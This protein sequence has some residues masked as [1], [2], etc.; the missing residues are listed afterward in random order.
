MTPCT[1]YF[2]ISVS[3][4]RIWKWFWVELSVYKANRSDSEWNRIIRH[5][6]KI[7][8]VWKTCQIHIVKPQPDGSSCRISGQNHI[9]RQYRILHL[10]WLY[11]IIWKI[12]RTKFC[13][14]KNGYQGYRI[15]GVTLSILSNLKSP[16]TAPI[17]ARP[18]PNYSRIRAGLFILSDIRC[19]VKD[20]S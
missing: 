14:P 8:Y 4:E 5:S 20:C 3:V 11:R 18:E 2:L 12:K 15:S 6:P 17:F 19:R 1:E 9:V 16:Y 13:R 10:Y 7:P